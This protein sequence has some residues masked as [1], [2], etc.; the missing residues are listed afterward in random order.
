[1]L[2]V[3]EPQVLAP[4]SYQDVVVGVYVGQ[5]GHKGIITGSGIHTQ[6][7]PQKSELSQAIGVKPLVRFFSSVNEAF[8]EY[9]LEIENLLV[10]GEK[11]MVKY[12]IWGL[13][14][15]RMLGVTAGGSKMKVSGLDIFR[16]DDG[17]VVE[18]W[19]ANHKIEAVA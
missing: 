6:N 13:M 1:M 18:Y 4:V 5:V 3:L 7:L 9:V 15:G 17:I 16:L 11:V 19:N 8:P 12:S 14:Q 10:K 2:H